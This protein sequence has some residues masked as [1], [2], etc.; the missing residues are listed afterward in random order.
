M[1]CGNYSFYRK[2]DYYR[3]W[4]ECAV[5]PEK[6]ELARSSHE[7]YDTA[8]D[9]TKSQLPPTHPIRLG[10]ALSFAVFNYEILHEKDRAYGMAKTAFD[11]AMAEID[12]LNEENYKE[13]TLIMQLLRDNLQLW[14]CDKPFNGKNHADASRIYIY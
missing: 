7:A 11:E 3:Y 4:S 8:R 10:Q 14:E 13:S 9:L 2:A 12:S 1:H 5:Q 6:E